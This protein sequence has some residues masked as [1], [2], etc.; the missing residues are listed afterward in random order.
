MIIFLMYAFVKSLLKE[1][2]K[3]VS[4]VLNDVKECI[5]VRSTVLSQFNC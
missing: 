2:N 1:K 3:F 5:G 4:P